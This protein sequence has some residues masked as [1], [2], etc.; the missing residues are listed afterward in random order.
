[1]AEAVST[2]AAERVAA[3]AAAQTL[4]APAIS[5]RPLEAALRFSVRVRNPSTSRLDMP[6]NRCMTSEGM[7]VARLGPDEWLALGSEASALEAHW[8]QNLAGQA[9]SLVDVS[10]RQVAIEVSGLRARE[11]LNGGCPL[12]LS[13]EA[14]PPGAATR[15]LLGKAEIILMR[16][17]AALIYR[18][19]CW[20]SF[21]PYVFGLLT[22]V[23]S[24][25]AAG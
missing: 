22:Q 14:F 24:E 15:T 10:H 9:H 16:P 19:E 11:V 2:V 6:I 20:R 1:M 8:R 23:A 4:C 5:V 25:F 18:V 21:A 13:D 17:T 7:T 12:D 3:L